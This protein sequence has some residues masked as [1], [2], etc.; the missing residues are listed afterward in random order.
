MALAPTPAYPFD[1]GASGVRGTLVRQANEWPPAPFPQ[2]TVWL[3]WMDDNAPPPGWTDSTIPSRTDAKGDF[4]VI[5]RL[6]TNQIARTDAM[7]RMRVRVAATHA[8]STRF[9]PELQIRP[10]YVADVQQSF[11]WNLF[12]P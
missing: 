2:D 9:S 12:T 1:A 11:A 10:G 3:Q 5:V 7:E 6:A 8:G 4:A